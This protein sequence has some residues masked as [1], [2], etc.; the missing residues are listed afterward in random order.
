MKQK[1]TYVITSYSVQRI[2][3]ETLHVTRSDM[4]TYCDVCLACC[5]AVE[6]TDETGSL[7]YQEISEPISMVQPRE[8]GPSPKAQDYY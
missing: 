6:C 2:E 1:Q 4:L 3:T 7:V 5:Y 8:Y